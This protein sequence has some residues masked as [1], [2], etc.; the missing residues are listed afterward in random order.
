M[1]AVRG[2]GDSQFT[3]G[4]DVPYIIRVSDRR[5]ISRP[6]DVARVSVSCDFA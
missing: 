5:L 2:E 4:E 3:G 6:G 1:L